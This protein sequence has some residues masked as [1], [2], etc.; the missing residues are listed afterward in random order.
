MFARANQVSQGNEYSQ[1]T[2]I[3]LAG[4]TGKQLTPNIAV[5]PGIFRFSDI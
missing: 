5:Q 4:D 2:E 1:Q 3:D